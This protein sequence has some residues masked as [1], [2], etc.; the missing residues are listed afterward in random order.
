[1]NLFTSFGYFVHERDDKATIIA[2]SKGLKNGGIFV[3]DFLNAKKII[4][5]LIPS[6][7]KEING[8]RF[9][10]RREARNGHICK[11]IQVNDNSKELHF[12]EKVKA[13][14]LHAFRELFA[15]C[16]LEIKDIRG[17]YDL[18]P[19]DEEQSDRLILIAQKQNL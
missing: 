16:G 13:L 12:S 4:R 3:I 2:V 19:F 9:H 17:D 18:N 7:E 15:C 14:D 10:I 1:M 8:I 5:T 11:H 6:E